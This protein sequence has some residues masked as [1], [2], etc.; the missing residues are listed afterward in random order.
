MRLLISLI[1]ALSTMTSTSQNMDIPYTGY[2]DTAQPKIIP[3]KLQIHSQ[4]SV[5]ELQYDQKIE[6]MKC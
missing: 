1:L 3:A 5:F 2:F 6:W 4:L